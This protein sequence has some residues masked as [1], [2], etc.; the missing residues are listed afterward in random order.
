MRLQAI[1]GMLSEIEARGVEYVPENMD[2]GNRK[3]E[4]TVHDGARQLG[5]A[6]SGVE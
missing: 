6:T 4:K 2:A 1:E 3:A 5:N